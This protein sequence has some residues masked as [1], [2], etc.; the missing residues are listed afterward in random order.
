MRLLQNKTVIWLAECWWCWLNS[1]CEMIQ[2]SRHASSMCQKSWRVSK[3]SQHLDEWMMDWQSIWDRRA[4][5]WRAQQSGG[6]PP[7]PGHTSTHTSPQSSLPV[8]SGL[9]KVC[10][11]K[12]N[13]VWQLCPSSL[14]FKIILVFTDLILINTS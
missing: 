5:L 2:L 7:R 10:K 1:I 13:N 11:G 3:G 9:Y 14:N 12:K 6:A 8:H 4:S